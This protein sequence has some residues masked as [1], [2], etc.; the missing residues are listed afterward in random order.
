MN[1]KRDNIKFYSETIAATLI[2]IMAVMVAFSQCSISWEQTKI[3]KLQTDIAKKKFLPTFIISAAQIKGEK[4]D[5]YSEDR[6]SIENKGFPISEFNCKTIVVYNI[7]ITKIP[8]FHKEVFI[9]INGYYSGTF[10]T[11]KGDGLIATIEGYR[12]NIRAAEFE[13]KFSEH[14]RS[15]NEIGNIRILRFVKIS[16]KDTFGAEHIEYFDV[17]LIYGANKM[18][19]E[20]GQEIFKEYNEKLEYYGFPDFDQITVEGIHALI[21]KS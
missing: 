7:E 20:K 3:M 8:S 12:N 11:G 9:P 19:P 5:K 1:I 18:T 13:W 6:I 15:K 10:H 16:Y 17:P 14:C 4:T 2:S 21:N